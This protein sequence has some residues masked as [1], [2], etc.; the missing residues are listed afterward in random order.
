MGFQGTQLVDESDG[1]DEDIATSIEIAPGIGFNDYVTCDDRLSICASEV[2]EISE[3]LETVNSD[4]DTEIENQT[5]SETVT[6]SNALKGLETV[7]TYIMQH[8]VND[9]IFSSLHKIEK[10]LFRAMNQENSQT[11]LHQYFQISN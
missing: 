9:A 4:S 10:E 11:S 5:P 8:D 6:F 1:N 7:K 2:S 3:L